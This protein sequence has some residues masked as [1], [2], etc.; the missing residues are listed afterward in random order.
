[1]NT[2]ARLM[3]S[4]VEYKGWDDLEGIRETE[5]EGVWFYRS[6]GGNQRQPFTYQSGIIMLGQGKKNIYIGERP[7]TYAAGD[8]LVVGVPMPLECEALPVDGEPLLGLSINIDSQRLHSLVKKLEDQGFL[9]SYCNKHKQNSSG[10]ESTPMEEQM[11]DSFTRLIKTLHCDIEANILG[12]ALVSEIVYRALTG[13]EGR[14]LFDL[15]HHDGHYARVAK[16]LSKVHEEY[17]QT[18]TVQSLADEANMSVSAFH[19][20]FRNVTFES[21][22]QYLKKVR[23]NKA[24]ELIQLEGLRISDA[25]RRVGY[26]S[27]SQFSREFKRHFNTTPRAV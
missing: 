4:Y 1:M 10:L 7:V 3:Q 26:S 5:I 16:A 8:Y 27:P 22:L 20:A 15:A 19:N 24:K 9:E 13:S 11:L 2:L 17:D 14:V 23:L 25:A 21:P 12:D 18:I 6:S